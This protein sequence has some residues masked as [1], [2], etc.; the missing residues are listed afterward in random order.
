VLLAVGIGSAF[1][2]LGIDLSEVLSIRLRP[3]QS[4]QLAMGTVAASSG[5]QFTLFQMM[6]A[7]AIVSVMCWFAAMLVPLWS[8]TFHDPT[9]A[10]MA[11]RFRRDAARW[12]RLA[13]ENPTLAKEYSKLAKT[14]IR[15]AVRSEQ[16]AKR[17]PP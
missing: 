11:R 16:R 13:S 9:D 1:L 6:L 8:A 7:I 10:E 12:T 17:S 3:G 2:L 14:S 5:P 15:S 4:K